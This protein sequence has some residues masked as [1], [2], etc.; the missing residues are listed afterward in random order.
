MRFIHRPMYTE[1]DIFKSELRRHRDIA[2]VIIV[3]VI[4]V[5]VFVDFVFVLDLNY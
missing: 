4:I 1:H 2:V 5:F 3:V